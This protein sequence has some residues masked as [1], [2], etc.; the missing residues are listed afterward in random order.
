[1]PPRHALL[2][3][4]V[5]LIWGTNFLVIDIGLADVP[6][7]L[8]LALRFAL[9]VFPAI[10]FIPPPRMA[11]RDIVLIG[12]FLSL[13]QFALL[14][15]ALALGLPPGLT[16]V[17][18]Q[19]QVLLTVLVGAFLLRERPTRRQLLGI[20]V[21]TA[22]LAVVVAGRGDDAPW[23]AV[24]ILAGASLCWAIGNVLTRRAGSTAGLSL[25]VWSGI[26]VPVPALVL[27]LVIDSPA[28]V[29]ESLGSLSVAAI[30][31]TLF[32]VV[33]SSFVGYGIWSYLLGR[34]PSSA[35]VPWALL[36]PVVGIVAAWAVQHEAPTTGT[37]IGGAVL[38]VGLGVAIT[39]RREAVR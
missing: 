29:W 37:L 39:G 31:S 38:L 18:H 12:S 9:V 14:Y 5:V 17:L 1:M 11:R 20:L 21:G 33:L 26:V 24:V 35:V 16:S 8:F 22:G 30:L 10:L 23:L 15:I 13:G 3:L 36:L 28:V 34:Y 25:V 7:L 6:P 2:A 19:A 4:L 27:S 32:A